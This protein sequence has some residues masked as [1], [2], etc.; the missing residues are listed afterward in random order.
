V[1]IVAKEPWDTS[2]E[3]AKTLTIKD[4]GTPDEV[5][6]MAKPVRNAATRL[7]AVKILK[8][9]VKNG[10]LVSRSG[11]PARLSTK[12]IGKM[13]SN[14]AVNTSCSPPAHY[15]AAANIDRL[16]ANAIE[17]WQFELNPAKNNDGLKNRRYLYAPLAYEDTLIVVKITVKE[18]LEATLQNKLYSIEAVT[19]DK[20]KQGC[21]YIN[22]S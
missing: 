6:E 16:F 8:A 3:K 4:F 19:M 13:V 22:R 17:P 9:M 1:K 18:Y 7:E 10:P 5:V 14:Q 11:I 15:L 12:A 21:R 2:S 20:K